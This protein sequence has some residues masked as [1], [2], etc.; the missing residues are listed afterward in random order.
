MYLLFLSN[1]FNNIL[2]QLHFIGSDLYIDCFYTNKLYLLFL[3]MYI[4]LLHVRSI[5]LRV[6]LQ[7]LYQ[8]CLLLIH[9]IQCIYTH[10]TELKANGSTRINMPMPTWPLFCRLLPLQDYLQPGWYFS[11]SLYSY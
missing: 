4:D 6:L 1:V 10:Y 9:Q 2:L 3:M 5:M 7:N 8:S 11:F